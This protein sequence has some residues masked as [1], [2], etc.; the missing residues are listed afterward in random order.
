MRKLL[1]I[2][3][4]GLF[5][6]FPLALIAA[7]SLAIEDHPRI[8]RK[9]ILTPEHIGRA[10]QIVDAHRY[11]IHPGMLVAA[12]VTSAD[13]DLAANYLAHRLGKGSAQVTLTDRKAI[14]RLSLPVSRTLPGG[15]VN[16][17]LNLQASVVE[18]GAMPQLRS[19][20]I[21]KLSLPDTLTDVIVLQLVHWLRRS[22]E[23]R[24]AFDALHLVRVSQKELSVVYRW[25]DGFSHEMR[26]SMI[27]EEERERLLRYQTLLAASSKKNGNVISLAE[28]L[29]PLMRVAAQRSLNGDA[30]AENRAVILVVAFHVLGVSP[31]RIFPAALTAWPRTAPQVVTVDGRD[32]FAKHFM[33]SA[34]IAAYADTALS[35]AIGLYKEIE[36]SRHGSGFSFNDVAADRAGTKFGEKAVASKTSAQQLQHRILSGLEDGDLMPPWSDLPEF[37]PEAEFKRRFGGIDAPGYRKMMQK[38]EQRVAALPVL[39]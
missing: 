34:A 3:L 32:D 21:G 29:P 22:P 28:I 12:R 30:L 8:D 33:V 35:D 31:E 26:A 9:V 6:I 37:M 15:Y 23:Y 39:Q 13:A 16:P 17:Y 7:L 18:A 20:Q 11:W 1:L 5:F 10:K 19:V 38:I 25:E 36:D 2:F 4:I 14:I 27:D 24:A